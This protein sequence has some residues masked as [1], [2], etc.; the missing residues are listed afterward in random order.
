MRRHVRL[1]F[2]FKISILQQFPFSIVEFPPDRCKKKMGKKFLQIYRF[3]RFSVTINEEMIT[4][5]ALCSSGEGGFLVGFWHM[6]LYMAGIWCT[7]GIVFWFCDIVP[8]KLSRA[9]QWTLI[10]VFGLLTVY[11]MEMAPGFKTESIRIQAVI[12]LTAA[13][14]FGP[15]TG[16]GAG[17]FSGLEQLVFHQALAYPA[18]LYMPVLAALIGTLFWFWGKC[19]PKNRFMNQ[20]VLR[21]EWGFCAAFFTEAL[22]I[23]LAFQLYPGSPEQ[24]L[25]TAWITGIPTV[26]CGGIGAFLN[27]Y[28]FHDRRLE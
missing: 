14:A 4:P 21:P 27:L 28:I 12:P 6:I 16:I 26:F 18:E 25:D 1:E 24:A 9:A 8:Q 2:L 19:C 3:I 15:V 20:G 7:A 10:V 11:A 13:I 17:I 5:P 23:F 22:Y